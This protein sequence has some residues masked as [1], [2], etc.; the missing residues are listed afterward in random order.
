MSTN[1]PAP[2]VL[3]QLSSFRDLS[4]QRL[5]ELSDRL[6]I[7]TAPK[8]AR[9]L[10]HGSQDPSLLFLLNGT[11]ELTAADGAKTRIGHQD[12]SARSPIARLRPS[13]YAVLAATP[14]TFLRID[15]DLLDDV[16]SSLENYS[17]LMIDTYQVDEDT[18]LSELNVENQLTVQIYEDLNSNQLLLPSLPDI[19]IRVGEAVNHDYANAN[20]VARVIENDPA[21]TAKI[22]KA[23]NS[24]LYSAGQPVRTVP[25]AVVRIGLERVHQLVITFA[26]RELFRSHSP[27]L[28]SRMRALWGHSRQVTAIASVMAAHCA[29]LS[30]ETALLA[31]LLH[32]IGS[33][34]VIGYARDFPEVVETPTMLDQTLR[35]LKG[36]LGSM[37]LA[38]WQLPEELASVAGNADN[39][40]YTH[41][42]HCD[43][44]D[45]VVVANLQA[46][47][48]AGE[49][50]NPPPESVPA[51]AKLGIDQHSDVTLEQ[52]LGEAKEQIRETLALLQA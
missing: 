5:Q 30:R 27:A 51:F 37:I 6:H 28:N 38:K 22:L 33:V 43:Y 25:E 32:D 2:E 40:S 24:V 9:L 14:V 36:Q 44:V 48:T 11:L 18:E 29:R 49:P 34:A 13:R 23:A 47:K 26:L 20:R 42:G 8:G 19:A 45:L 12:P 52:I 1:H 21:I 3:R 46:L 17:S 35:R 4:A 15:T 16:D 41:P 50:G 10:E 7:Y 31:G 39:W